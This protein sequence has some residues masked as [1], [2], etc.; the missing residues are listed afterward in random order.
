MN[1]HI[2][3]KSTKEYNI[4]IYN[5]LCS[6]HKY[7][8]GQVLADCNLNICRTVFDRKQFHDKSYNVFIYQLLWTQPHAQR[9]CARTG[10]RSHLRCHPYPI[11]QPVK[12]GHTTGVYV[13]Y[14]F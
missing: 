5:L 14:S 6:T 4:S 13:P 2:T 7:L 8:T 10:L 11:P 1:V 12:V 9:E 3:L